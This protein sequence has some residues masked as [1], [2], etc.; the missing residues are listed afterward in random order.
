MATARQ[1]ERSSRDWFQEAERTYSE[2]HQG[3]PWCGGSHR[4]FCQRRNATV[5]FYCQGCDFQVSHDTLVGRFRMAPGV[6]DRA[7][8]IIPET[9]FGTPKTMSS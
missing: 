7:D 9:M 2:K 4:V 8:D 3:C 6:D 1:V 5:I